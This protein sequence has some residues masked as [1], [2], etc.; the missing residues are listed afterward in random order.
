MDQKATLCLPRLNHLTATVPLP[1]RPI[2]R[3]HGGKF[4]IAPWVASL[5][6]T[7][8]CYVEPFG[9]MASVLLKKP[10]S[11]TEVYNDLDNDVVTLFT[12]LRDEH[13]AEALAAQLRATP[14]ARAEYE[15]AFEPSDV[16]VERARRFL[17][18]SAM[19]V[20]SD[21]ATRV[22]RSGFRNKRTTDGHFDISP[23]RD[24]ANLESFLPAF[25][26]RLRSV[27]IECRAASEV[28]TSFDSPYTLIYADPPYLPETQNRGARAE[29]PTRHGYRD[30]FDREHHEALLSQLLQC[31]SMVMLSG[32]PSDLYSQRLVGW[33]RFDRGARALGGGER[34]ECLWMNPHCA[35]R[36]QA[37]RQQ[38]SLF[39]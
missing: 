36:H 4:A 28:I 17:I 10:Q 19:G 7:H 25:H 14:F 35:E 9:G 2:S 8:E 15:A 30:I 18:R 22:A 21:S 6:P 3:Y 38:E 29:G 16:D 32:Y 1:N 13:A 23:A 20:G 12:V 24:F 39:D 26:D 34:T 11:N 33:T 5:M 31:K 27:I 37:S